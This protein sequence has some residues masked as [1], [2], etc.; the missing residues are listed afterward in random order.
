MPQK[1]KARRRE[2]KAR[3]EHAQRI[4][5]ATRSSAGGHS[6]AILLQLEREI[7]ASKKYLASLDAQPA[8]FGRADDPAEMKP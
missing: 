8:G 1:H 7:H 2:I 6:H 3:L 4:L 5:S